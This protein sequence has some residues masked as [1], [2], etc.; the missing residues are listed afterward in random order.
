MEGLSITNMAKSIS[1]AE[2]VK[3]ALQSG[4]A[5]ASTV[6]TLQSL[7]SSE[8]SCTTKP[9]SKPRN[10]RTTAAEQQSRLTKTAA[11][12]S[13][14]IRKPQAV[15][16]HEDTPDVLSP[17]Q[18]Y[19]LATS[20]INITLKTLTESL[21]ERQASRKVF[22]SGDGSRPE[23][24]RRPERAHS[25]RDQ[26]LQPRS[27]NT[28]PKPTS[29]VKSPKRTQESPNAARPRTLSVSNHVQATSECARLGFAYLRGVDPVK[30]GARELPPLQLENGM[31]S[32]IGKL[33][34]HGLDALAVR[35]LRALKWRLE[36]AAC[37]SDPKP[38]VRP[39][40][41]SKTS[42][43]LATLL[44]LQIDRNAT[45]DL[46]HLA[47][48]YQLCVLKIIST[49]RKPRVIEAAVNYLALDSENS[50]AQLFLS[51][52]AKSQ[53]RNKASKQLEDLSAT[54]LALCPSV[55][56]AVD[57]VA[58]DFLSHLDPRAAFR[59]QSAALRLRRGIVPIEDS[60][61]R[62]ERML[63]EPFSKCLSAVVR[64]TTT[65]SSSVRQLYSLST[66][67]YNNLFDGSPGL[68]SHSSFSISRTLCSLAEQAGLPDEAKK[69]ACEL[70]EACQNLPENHALRLAAQT[71]AT[72]LHIERSPKVD[73]LAELIVTRLDGNSTDYEILLEELARASQQSGVKEG[74]RYTPSLVIAAARYAQRF[75]RA[76][77]GRSTEYASTVIQA[78]LAQH[79]QPSTTESDWIS[80]EAVSIF[81][82]AGVLKGVVELSNA[83]SPRQVWRSS[84]DAIYLERAI[85]LLVRKCLRT[86]TKFE[87]D[88]WQLSSQAKGTTLECQLGHVV[89]LAYKAK[90]YSNMMPVLDSILRE[91]SA[92]YT[93]DQFPIRRAR[94]ATIAHQFC[95]D[96]PDLISAT[97]LELWTDSVNLSELDLAEDKGLLPF[98]DDIRASLAMSKA[99][100]NR[101]PSAAELEPHLQ[102]WTA[103]ITSAPNVEVLLARVNDPE[104]LFCLLRAS[105]SFQQVLGHEKTTTM[106]LQLRA[107][108]GLK[109]R[110]SYQTQEQPCS[111]LLELADHYLQ[112][113]Y[114][115]RAQPILEE[116]QTLLAQDKE[117]TVLH[118]HYEIANAD[119]LLAMD[120]P[121]AAGSAL[122]Q[123]ITL[124]AKLPATK[125]SKL[126]RR[127]YEQIYA[128]GWLV[129]SRY[130]LAGGST[131]G[132]VAAGKR[133]MKLF[134]S[135]WKHVEGAATSKPAEDTELTS[136]PEPEPEQ[137]G[138]D[139]LVGGIK[140]LQ[141][142]ASKGDKKAQPPKGAAY[143]PILP[144]LCR[145]F[146]H[147]S[148]LYSYHGQYMEA[149]FYCESA[150]KLAESVG[151]GV[152]CSR[153]RSHRAQLL[154]LA[155]RLEDAELCLSVDD[156][157]TALEP[158]LTSVEKLR[159]LAALKMKEGEA[160]DASRLLAQAADAVRTMARQ[161]QTNTAEA[162]N[163]DSKKCTT[164]RAPRAPAKSVP[165]R[166]TAKPA[167]K[168]NRKRPMQD[169]EQRSVPVTCYILDKLNMEIETERSLALLQ[170][171]QSIEDLAN[172][173][174]HIGPQ[175]SLT[176]N[177]LHLQY[178]T[179][180][181]QASEL[182]NADFCFSMLPESTISLPALQVSGRRASGMVTSK[183]STKPG[184]REKAAT[185]NFC[186]L[187]AQACAGLVN[188]C[189][190]GARFTTAD[191]HTRYS[192]LVNSGMLLSAASASQRKGEFDVVEQAF[193]IDN[194]R[195]HAE[196]GERHLVQLER[197]SPE[198]GGF[199][200]FESLSSP[201]PAMLSAQDYSMDY[202]D[203]LPKTWTAV[204]MCLNE[205]C[206]ELYVAR[207]IADQ[208]PFIVR[209]PFARHKPESDEEESFDFD[210]G[211]AELQ[212]IIELS[213]YSCHSTTSE[214]K[215]KTWWAERETLDKRL[216][217]L[218][219]NIENVW[220]GGFKG[221]F[222]LRPTQRELLSSFRKSFEGILDRHLPSRR[223]AKSSSKKMALD[224]KVLELFIGLGSDQDGAIDLD[225]SL[226]D[227]LYFVVDILQFNGERN[228]YDEIDLDS[229]A[230]ETLDALR[231]YHETEEASKVED[232][233]LI[234]V[235]DR[236][237]HVF[238]W[239]SM[240]CLDGASVSRV[241]SMQSLKERISA[242]R[243]HYHAPTNSVSD[244][245]T[246]PR[247]SGSFILN[248]SS[249]LPGTETALL[250]TLSK[251][252]SRG[253]NSTWKSLV[254][255]A[256]SEQDFST[257]LQTS[258]ITL[259]FG[260]GAGS[261]YIR[262]RTVKKLPACSGVV[263]L[264]GCS[265]GAVTEYGE[266]EPQAVPLA[267]LFAGDDSAS[268]C[269][270][271]AATLWDVTDRDID[272]FS[273]A[274]GEKW[275][276]WG[277]SSSSSTSS[278]TAAAGGLKPP[279]TP[280]RKKRSRS[281][282]TPA[283]LPKTPSKT[284]NHTVCKTAKTPSWGF[285]DGGEGGARGG[286]S[287]SLAVAESREACYLR[288][289]NGAATV[290]YGVPVYL[291]D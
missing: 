244:R 79:G 54:L 253:N 144:G 189:G 176:W 215:K 58:C 127:A 50:V 95:S 113:G 65:S 255:K 104:T 231:A 69:W 288:F 163:T 282:C 224:D 73:K 276:L 52:L 266:L 125:V 149:N 84:K 138:V 86:P 187:L 106:L 216:H 179:A 184:R 212:E 181:G 10:G 263:W 117:T 141:L 172:T 132:A 17:K 198:S 249:N 194:A 122:Q 148:S 68:Q 204:S 237:L 250:P 18:R 102:R 290:V 25:M 208:S 89:A 200:W 28:T 20:V 61:D 240:P 7:L 121:E 182:L 45:P 232:R 207:Y 153:V 192:M 201:K 278:F 48:A 185:P 2:I 155:G 245:L 57:S 285:S 259:Y 159:A 36:A 39:D 147:L 191:L 274:V 40:S 8:T 174:S 71:R 99:F 220:F 168:T 24:P 1:Q 140:K 289:L 142:G 87:L 146:L 129:Y 76:Y 177:Q 116:A 206:T 41:A 33:N 218:L 11:T 114:A 283:R 81:I 15:A 110:L 225:E 124:H 5:S 156:E 74:V 291:G 136:E 167:P 242:V 37:P 16:I 221:L 35:E 257:T 4:A 97:T 70:Q 31:L 72:V 175:Q 226:A 92:V 256:P 158:S 261:Q 47:S 227:L 284:P 119:L 260:H 236:R 286:K 234:L 281:P 251:L 51:Y 233:H 23:T 222:S 211:K 105:T 64:R 180:F 100:L 287:L 254:G 3:D 19:A 196:A 93:E 91:L 101:R 55:S 275:G 90:H 78:A 145:S 248:P 273:L 21:K 60:I 166:T 109:L 137:T 77:P 195:I 46:L 279:K 152:L 62:L 202:I 213:N 243:E 26:A 30:L 42:E 44:G 270:A 265:S 32:L 210:S 164:L 209:L 239:E 126:H 27:G 75:V 154:T 205:T 53:E 252:S 107:D 34:A 130:L 157:D 246:V 238:P 108:V 63:V 267:Y 169:S 241:G 85:G 165:S 94:V 80:K 112:L 280:S 139:G 247:G 258:P 9:S 12:R 49:S 131:Y 143:W 262:P 123:T 197:Q 118:I 173:G 162:P 219:I 235:L 135:I 188:D 96:Y 183:S 115:E 83:C 193:A 271:V 160:A 230:T 170:T 229:M 43:T 59:L 228:A 272:R 66:S 214:T 134:N 199:G 98:L 178:A 82:Q 269:K 171:G 264:M 268:N 22:A 151:S 150:L 88:E 161:T 103:I 223:A 111:A 6:T 133:S 217:E 14:R 203:T 277:S 128:R 13:A 190:L 186:Q 38:S 120:R 56:S 29:P 67:A